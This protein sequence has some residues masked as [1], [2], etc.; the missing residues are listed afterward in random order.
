MDHWQGWSS[1]ANGKWCQAL[2][3]ELI[4]SVW[5][6]ASLICPTLWCAGRCLGA[7]GFW[8]GGEAVSPSCRVCR[9]AAPRAGR[10][11]SHTAP[12]EGIGAWGCF[13][14][15]KGPG[16]SQAEPALGSPLLWARLAWCSCRLGRVNVQGRIIPVPVPPPRAAAAGLG[17]GSTTSSLGVWRTV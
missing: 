15:G 7:P 13:S 10:H 2:H 4:V 17:G 1:Q 6:P 14:P 16:R 12:H 9:A 3:T 11:F 8:A 5:A